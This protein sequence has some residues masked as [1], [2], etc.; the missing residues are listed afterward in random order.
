MLAAIGFVLSAPAGAQA[1]TVH[2]GGFKQEFNADVKGITIP[3]ARSDGP[4]TFTLDWTTSSDV[5]A[6]APPVTDVEIKLPAGVELRKQFQTGGTVCSAAK[7]VA[8]NRDP[9]ACGEAQIGKGSI[10]LDFQPFVSHTVK[11]TVYVFLGAGGNGAVGSLV[12]LAVPDP[13]D[14]FVGANTVVR[15]T[16][17][18]ITAPIYRDST[19]GFGLRMEMPIEIDAPVVVS[20]RTFSIEMTGTAKPRQLKSSKGR[21]YFWASQPTCKKSA[22][23]QATFKYVGASQVTVGDSVPTK[24]KCPKAAKAK[25][26]K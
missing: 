16:K 10:D 1:D 22:K 13:G 17:P 6:V 12:I 7:L 2:Q 21:K 23:F 19:P 18:V 5:A 20:V 8:K 14:P 4:F 25:K 11:A 3:T 9:R 26:K 15:D 24:F